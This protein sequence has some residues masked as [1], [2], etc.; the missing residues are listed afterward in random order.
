M[1]KD[2]RSSHRSL[3]PRF[4]VLSYIFVIACG[5]RSV[6]KSNIHTII[7]KIRISYYG[8]CKD[9]T[10]FRMISLISEWRGSF[11]NVSVSE[12]F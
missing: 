10:T 4:C 11:E 5:K 7:R 8:W 9:S 6:L 3:T 12:L 2:L 1:V